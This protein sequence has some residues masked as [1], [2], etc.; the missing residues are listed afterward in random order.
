MV[1]NPAIALR[2]QRTVLQEK[3]DLS[4]AGHAALSLAPHPTRFIE[5]LAEGDNARDAVYALALMLPHRQAVWWACLAT[6]L[7]PDSDES[8]DDR[9]AIEAAE[10]W[11]QSG[12][13]E[14]AEQAGV[15]AERSNSARAPGWAAMAAFWSG[16]S[17]APRGQ[18][19]VAPPA[20]L[21]GVAVRTA[22]I[23]LT[24]DPLF[25]GRASFA[26]WLEIGLALMNGGNGRDAQ[27]KLRERFAAA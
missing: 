21:P 6:R 25:A 13:P 14:D 19:A 22:M 4:P 26:D 5:A 20:H 3:A 12:S 2:F 23:L 27:T 9:V 17:L 8:S 16:P 11:V 18:Q 1:S 10:R 24:H 15:V 7:L